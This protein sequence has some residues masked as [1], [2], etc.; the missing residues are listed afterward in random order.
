[1][2]K[3]K[4]VGILLLLLLIITNVSAE[5]TSVIL[6]ND[7][8]TQISGSALIMC[9]VALIVFAAIILVKILLASRS[10]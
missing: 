2:S 3:S 6:D 9:S 1:M 4:I 10:E 5:G 7:Q 8:T